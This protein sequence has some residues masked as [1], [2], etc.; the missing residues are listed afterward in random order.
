M[1]TNQLQFGSLW[2][3][4]MPRSP[5]HELIMI[6]LEGTASQPFQCFERIL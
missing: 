4:S 1:R 6:V 2:G 5:H 3:L